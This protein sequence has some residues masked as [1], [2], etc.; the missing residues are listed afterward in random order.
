M[1]LLIYLFILDKQGLYRYVQ[2]IN[3]YLLLLRQ[4]WPVGRSRQSYR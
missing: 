1:I 3:A 4:A 2:T